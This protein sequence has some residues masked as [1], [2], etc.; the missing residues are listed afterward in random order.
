[1]SLLT[2]DLIEKCKKYPLYSQDGKGG[3]A[4]VIARFYIPKEFCRDGAFNWIITEGDVFYTDGKPTDIEMFGYACL[5]GDIQNSELGYIMLS[6]LEEIN[7]NHNLPLVK[8]DMRFDENINLRDAL[9]KTLHYVPEFLQEPVKY[10]I[11]QLKDTEENRL[12]RFES[13]SMLKNGISDIKGAN[14]YQVFSDKY[15]NSVD[16]TVAFDNNIII[17]K[18]DDG[19]RWE[20]AELY[21][22]LLNE[23]I[24]LG[25][26][27]KPVDGFC[28]DEKIVSSVLEFAKKYGYETPEYNIDKSE[29]EPDICEQEGLKMR[30]E[31]LQEKKLRIFEHYYERIIKERYYPDR[32]IRYSVIEYLCSFPKINPV[33]MA[34]ELNDK[35]YEIVFDDTSI[36]QSENNK[37]RREVFDFEYRKRVGLGT[38]IP[39]FLEEPT[40]E[41]EKNNIED[42]YEREDY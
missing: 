38:A 37:K 17:A 27:N 19:N 15:E 21:R 9:Q 16:M 20:G 13:I 18:D 24:I 5:N 10:E 3:D 8:R 22:F 2:K 34:R 33:Y 39:M 32:P 30:D 40:F 14:Y 6:E 28:I 1:M 42:D 12:L 41:Q 31:T 29:V 4:T 35:G 36:T 23:V 25:A 26:D 11:Y 7:N